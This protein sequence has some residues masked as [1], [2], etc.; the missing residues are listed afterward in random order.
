MITREKQSNEN[1]S[2]ESTESRPISCANFL[3]F[4]LIFVYFRCAVC[5]C[6]F[7]ISAVIPFS[8]LLLR[9]IS[10][11]NI[12]ILPK[13]REQVLNITLNWY[14]CLKDFQSKK[15]LRCSGSVHKCMPRGNIGGLNTAAAKTNYD[16]FHR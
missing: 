5:V 4:D 8:L 14:E 6:V 7:F 12:A 2:P 13:E 15:C 16:I 11:S 10:S 1:V 9:T 3:F